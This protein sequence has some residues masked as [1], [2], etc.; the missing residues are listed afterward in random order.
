MII[1]IWR[2]TLNVSGIA[3]V[4]L[5]DVMKNHNHKDI[6][7]QKRYR[8]T[9]TAKMRFQKIRV[10]ITAHA[11]TFRSKTCALHA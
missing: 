8:T 7:H 5:V 1:A 9:S 10:G 6:S 2:G 3:W 4:E 11:T